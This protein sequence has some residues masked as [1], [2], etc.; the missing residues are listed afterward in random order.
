M[1]SVLKRLWLIGLALVICSLAAHATP[2]YSV[3][4]QVPGAQRPLLEN[5]LDLYRWRDNERMDLIQLRRLV[6]EA[7]A[8]IRTLS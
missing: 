1:R 7:P 5:H 6:E 4:L 8:Q 2:F 3:S